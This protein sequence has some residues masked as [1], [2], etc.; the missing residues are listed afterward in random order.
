MNTTKVHRLQRGQ[1][2][3][4]SKRAVQTAIFRQRD[5]ERFGMASYACCSANCTGELAN[6]SL[7][8]ILDMKGLHVS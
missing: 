1:M 5:D 4:F 7:T 2:F 6:K 8:E 3:R